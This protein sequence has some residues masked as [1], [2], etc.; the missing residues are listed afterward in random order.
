MSYHLGMVSHQAKIGS[1]YAFAAILLSVYGTEVCPYVEG[2]G[3][4]GVSPVFALSFLVAAAIRPTI[5]GKFA[6]NP[7]SGL[8]LELMLWTLVGLFLS[9]FNLVVHEFPLASGLKVTV[10]CIALGLP[11]ACYYGLKLEGDEI[12]LAQSQPHRARPDGPSR[13]I[14]THLYRFL[15][16]SQVL[17]AAVIVLLFFKDL[18]HI[19]NAQ[20]DD[21]KALAHDRHR[22]SRVFVVLLLANAPS[23]GPMQK[24]QAP[25]EST[26]RP[27]GCC[28]E[29]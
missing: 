24:S 21:L 12:L 7:S 25:A 5:M 11:V 4:V 1:L 8:K 17:L 14:P 20:N 28:C 19:E 29:R 10:G 22:S 15:V 6:S 2:L 16:L 9:V 13:S 3:L 23:H 26:T 18:S 27:N